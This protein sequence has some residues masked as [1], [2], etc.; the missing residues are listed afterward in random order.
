MHDSGL[1]EGYIT[2]IGVTGLMN[3]KK[4]HLFSENRAPGILRPLAAIQ[5]F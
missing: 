5:A 3:F 1:Y 2:Q 4:G